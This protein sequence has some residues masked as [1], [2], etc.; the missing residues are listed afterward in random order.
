MIQVVVYIHTYIHAH[1]QLKATYLFLYTPPSLILLLLPSF[2]YLLLY[3][4]L[5]HTTRKL[6][7]D[8]L[9]LMIMEGDH[10]ITRHS[11]YFGSI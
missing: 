7:S 2:L 10:D 11:A 8:L 4:Q 1:T 6:Y 9:M 3:I 5:L